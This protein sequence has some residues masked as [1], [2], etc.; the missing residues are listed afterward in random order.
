M[1]HTTQLTDV[2]GSG[3]G[4][5]EKYQQKFKYRREFHPLINYSNDARVFS[6]T[7]IGD[8]V[9]SGSSNLQQ[10]THYSLKIARTTTTNLQVIHQIKGKRL[11][12]V[13]YREKEASGSCTKAGSLSDIKK[14]WVEYAQC[15]YFAYVFYIYCAYFKCHT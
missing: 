10:K 5:N 13:Y 14:M 8:L 4:D 6:S 2:S 1:R 3:E 9:Y 12:L 11:R 15:P 7:A